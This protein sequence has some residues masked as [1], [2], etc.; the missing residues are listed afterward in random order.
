M[1]RR[2][3]QTGQNVVITRSW[4]S[5]VTPGTV[6]VIDEQI[7]GGYFVRITAVFSN[8]R[9]QRS[10]ET[11]SV[12]FSRAELAETDDELMLDEGCSGAT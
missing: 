5:D 1:P 8:A 2:R 7:R 12:F 11:R 3:F 6:G 4:H 9:G 10:A